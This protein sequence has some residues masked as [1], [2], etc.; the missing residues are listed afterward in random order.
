MPSSGSCT[1]SV[2]AHRLHLRPRLG[3][4]ADGTSDSFGSEACVERIMVPE[5]CTVLDIRVAITCE[6]Y[7]FTDLQILYRYH[8]AKCGPSRKSRR[9]RRGGGAPRWAV[10]VLPVLRSRA[11]HIPRASGEG[12]EDDRT[13]VVPADAVVSYMKPP[14]PPLH[15][16]SPMYRSSTPQVRCTCASS[17]TGRSPA[18]SRPCRA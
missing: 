4:R 6:L 8:R 18:R 12:V 2:A 1:P 15:D 11:G 16:R 14:G 3:G 7:R 17:S 5:T 13:C 9:A 10:Q